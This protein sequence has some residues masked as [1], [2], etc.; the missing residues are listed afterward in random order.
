[1][2]APTTLLTRFFAN[3]DRLGAR[4]ISH[5]HAAGRWV[6][7]GWRTAAGLVRDLASGLVDLGH[8]SG[9]ALAI[10]STTRR[11]WLLADLGNLAAGGVTVGVYPTM[12]PEQTR[13]I[14]AHCEARFAVVE[15]AGQLAKLD[16]VRSGL[17]RLETVIVIDAAGV[18]PRPDLLTLTD[19]LARGHAA[20]HDIQQ[21]VAGL[22]LE[23]AAMFVYT[24]G[25]TGPPK[26]AML[27]HGNIVAALRA[28]EAVPIEPTDR[29]FSFLPL[30]HVLQRVVDYYGLWLGVE[31]FYGRGI[32]RVTEDLVA[33]RPTV[34]AAVPRIFEKVY[35]RIL[36]T[37]S[38]SPPRKRQIFEWAMGVGRQVSRL[39]QARQPVPP[40]LAV[41]HRLARALVFDKLRERLGGRIR[42][43]LTGGAPIAAEILEFF[44]AAD[45][46][47]LEAWGMTETFSAGSLNLPG[48]ARFGSIGKPLP[49]VEMKLDD[50]GEILVRGPNV[51]AGYHRDEEA[52]RAA[53]TGDGFFR[54]GD[55]ARRDA[56]GY[57]FIVD[58]KKDLIITAAGKNIAPQNIENLLK[59]DPRISQAMVIGDRRPYVVA[60]IAVAPELRDQAAGDELER[61]VA[62]IIARRNE[63]LASYERVKKFRVLPTDLTQESG[64]LT[65]TLKL[66][67]KIVAEKYAALI[68]EMYAEGRLPVAAVSS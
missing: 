21:R 19:L 31:G 60:L 59:T 14:V 52:T 55:I 42:L 39:R 12:T 15:D 25:T 44:D 6:P 38:Q 63:E 2:T 9:E 34:M 37:A 23:D 41:Q 57:Y 24:S 58:R 67:R 8:Q 29:G 13:Y 45:I 3:A 56:D 36:E 32:D 35:A 17:P 54:T 10:V 50:D 43:F 1:M 11:E 20:R 47:I 18:P 16:A 40:A 33:A 51:F 65:P 48:E 61:V 49:G 5:Y 22:R 68:D 62:E 66:R 53:F 26:G 28:F 64:E 4:P 46:T 27:T 30:A 7:M